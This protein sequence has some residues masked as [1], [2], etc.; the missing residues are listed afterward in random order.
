[1]NE[2]I[3]NFLKSLNAD[4]KQI[5]SFEDCKIKRDYDVNPIIS[6]NIIF[7]SKKENKKISIAD[8]VGYDYRCMNLDTNLLNNLSWFFDRDGDSYHSRSVSMLDIPQNEVMEQL[9]YSFKR[10]PICLTEVDSGKYNIGSN[11][12]HRFHVIKTHF[13]NELSKINPKDKIAIKRLKEKYS[14]VANITEIDFVKT[15]SAYMLKLLDENLSLENHYNAD[16]ELTDKSCLINYL[17]P[18]EKVVL[19][20]NQLIETVNKKLNKFLRTAS[21]KEVKQFNETI[22]NSF[23]FESFKDYYDFTLNQNQKGEREW[24]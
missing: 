11:G 8:V 4:L 3:I 20:D 17:N 2:T 22:K 18:E 16:Y 9:D 21:R 13:L 19:T 15:Y 7:K 24:S 12:M 5:N 14:F 1:M 10:E 23:K 6:R